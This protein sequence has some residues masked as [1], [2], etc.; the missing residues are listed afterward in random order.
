L[1][2]AFVRTWFKQQLTQLTPAILT[3][4]FY[5]LSR[6]LL[7]NRTLFIQQQDDWINWAAVSLTPL[8]RNN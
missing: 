6:G 2:V 1:L 5:S 3:H 8:L 7:F 4:V